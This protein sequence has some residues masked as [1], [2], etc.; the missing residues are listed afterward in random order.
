MP[1]TRG[2]IGKSK[3]SVECDVTIIMQISF[4]VFLYFYIIQLTKFCCKIYNRFTVNF[5]GFALFPLQL[6]VK[7]TRFVGN[8]ADGGFTVK[9][10]TYF[11]QRISVFARKFS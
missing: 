4:V 3:C 9:F 7:I 10:T 5:T 8:I 11:V 1:E 6:T 2:D